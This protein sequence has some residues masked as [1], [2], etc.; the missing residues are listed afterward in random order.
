MLKPS[1]QTHNIHGV[2]VGE[3]WDCLRLDPGPVQELKTKYEAHLRAGGRPELVVDLLGVG[4]AG[5]AVLGHF[6]ALHRVARPAA[7]RL[8]FCN[9]DP[10][11]AE[12]FRVSKLEPLFTFVADRAAALAAADAPEPAHGPAPAPADPAG[13]GAA[14]DTPPEPRKPS[15]GSLLRSS[16]RRNLS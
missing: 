8:I 5:S 13:Q 7:G 10:T 9:V 14:G 2:L 16:R 6:V 15:G 11:V 1:V 3:F 12:V 4:F